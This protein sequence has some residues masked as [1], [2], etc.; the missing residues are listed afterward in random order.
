M[1]KGFILFAGISCFL[2]LQAQQNKIDS[3]RGLLIAAKTDTAKV[4]LLNQIAGNFVESRPDSNLFY[5]NQALE[6]SRK[7]NYNKGEIAALLHT[8]A[9][10]TLSGNYSKALENALDALK[11]PFISHA[12]SRRRK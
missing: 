12:V 1:K 7:I 2:H 5:A 9:G 3:L 10:F 11:K 4:N 8:S 6:L